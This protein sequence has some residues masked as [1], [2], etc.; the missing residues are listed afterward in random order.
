MFKT[1]DRVIFL[2]DIKHHRKNKIF[3][4]KDV[5]DFKVYISINLIEIIHYTFIPDEF[6]SLK[7]YRK[8]KLN[9]L[10]LSKEIE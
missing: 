2:S 10:C 8:L 5:S 1:G 7:D 9:K 3:T 4:V 6:I